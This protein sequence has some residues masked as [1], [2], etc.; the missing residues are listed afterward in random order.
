MKQISA[1]GIQINPFTRQDF[2]F[3][4]SEGIKKK[5]QIV[6]S[7]VNASSIVE[8]VNSI[9]LKVA[10]NECDLVNIDGMSLVWALRFFGYQVPERVACP[11]LAES[12]LRLAEINKYGV[13]LLGA[14]E[15]NLLSA[16][17]NIRMD[18]PNLKISGYRNG[19]FAHEDEDQ[20]AIMIEQSQAQILLLGLPSPQKELFVKAHKDKLHVNY[21]LGVG[22]FFDILSGSKKRAPIWMQNI[23]LE[24]FYRFIQEPLRLLDRYFLGNLKFIR[25]VVQ[26]KVKHVK[27]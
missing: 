21:F 22:G 25:I 15:E 5:K 14:S 19:Y 11:D 18:Y 13:F 23:G 3:I 20:I 12:V 4:I 8:L 16:I 10:Y 26:E 7:G 27:S 6:Q 1:F 9:D 17:N 24:W 2:L